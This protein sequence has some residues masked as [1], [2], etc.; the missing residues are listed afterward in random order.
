MKNTYLMYRCHFR[1]HEHRGNSRTI[2]SLLNHRRAEEKERLI[3]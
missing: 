1:L 3:T 2:D